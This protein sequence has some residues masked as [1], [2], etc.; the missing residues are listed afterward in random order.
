VP[1]WDGY[2]GADGEGPVVIMV[3]SL[4]EIS[5]LYVYGTYLQVCAIYA[6]MA[7]PPCG[8]SPLDIWIQ[9]RQHGST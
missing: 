2:V 7:V 3:K 8:A 5:S 9:P 4:E 6:S 1:I